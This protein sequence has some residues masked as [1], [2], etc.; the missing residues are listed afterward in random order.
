LVDGGLVAAAEVLGVGSSGAGAAATVAGA[1]ATGGFSIGAGTET[2]G[3]G[4]GALATARG[5]VGAAAGLAGAAVVALRVEETSRD[6]LVLE[7]VADATFFG[8][9]AVFAG[10]AGCDAG[11][12][13]GLGAGMLA[14]ATVVGAAALAL[15]SA[16]VVSGFAAALACTVEVLSVKWSSTRA[17]PITNAV[18]AAKTNPKWLLSFTEAPDSGVVTVGAF[19]RRV[20]EP[21]RT[22]PGHAY[23]PI[24]VL[25]TG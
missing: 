8:D 11:A 2:V 24:S 4:A 7:G 13:A 5:G 21:D 19:E 12:A 25:L 17:P 10:A 22:N 23:R 1:D 15:V 20:V 9:S 14:S 3:A 18:M 6:V 16:A